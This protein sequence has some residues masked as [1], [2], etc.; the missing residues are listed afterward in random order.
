[1]HNTI[2]ALDQT[3]HTFYFYRLSER[4]VNQQTPF[5]PKMFGPKLDFYSL[6][7]LL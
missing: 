2:Y 1:M 3:T 5:L 4:R 7:T 6:K